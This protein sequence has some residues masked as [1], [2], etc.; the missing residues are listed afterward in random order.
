MPFEI[1]VSTA[2]HMQ[3]DAAGGSHVEYAVE[4]RDSA[5]GLQVAA[6]WRRFRQ[7][8]TLRGQLK[9]SGF[10]P[11]ALPSRH[12]LGKPNIDQ[13]RLGLQR[14]L[15]EHVEANGGRISAPLAAW[16]AASTDRVDGLRSRGRSAAS[17][18]VVSAAAAVLSPRQ[19]LGDAWGQS[20]VDAFQHRDAVDSW[21]LVIAA[22]AMLSAALCLPGRWAWD[23]RSLFVGAS[24]ALLVAAWLVAGR[25][26]VL[27]KAQGQGS[28]QSRPPKE[29]QGS[30]DLKLPLLKLSPIAEVPS[31]SH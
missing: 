5:T 30:R 28:A 25:S 13:R 8:V 20:T 21:H 1:T 3:G 26:Q 29:L 17:E 11:L 23:L 4:C 6:G 12:L 14:A 18:R 15:R 31:L 9:A 19:S 24:Q 27:V 22:L 2:R 10:A 7:F 16:L